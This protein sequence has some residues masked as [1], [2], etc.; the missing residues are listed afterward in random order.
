M[1][2]IKDY[3]KIDEVGEKEINKFKIETTAKEIIPYKD[4]GIQG[5]SKTV[6]KIP[7]E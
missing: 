1:L 7:I 4:W 3:R 2:E 5:K 6:Y